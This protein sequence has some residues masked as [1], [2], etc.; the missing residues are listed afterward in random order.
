MDSGYQQEQVG[1]GRVL[2]TVTPASVP[3]AIGIPATMGAVLAL[4]VIASGVPHASALS[5][6]VR[7]AIAA[8]AGWWVYQWTRR[9]LAGR[10]DRNRSPGGT[11]VVSPGSIEARGADIAREQLGSLT[12]RNAL[13]SGRP[14]A[15]R[16]SFMLCA[17]HRGESTTLAGGMTEGT[18]RGLLTDVSRILRL[19]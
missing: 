9:W 7:L 8:S 17:E 14:K 12:V 15:A 13:I 3:R 18:A 1:N 4:I 10:V 16:V 6:A 19:Q 11:F 2:F 5:L